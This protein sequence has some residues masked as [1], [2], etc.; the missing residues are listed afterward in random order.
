MSVRL[1]IAFAVLCVSAA[2]GDTLLHRQAP[3]RVFGRTSD[4]LFIDNAGQLNGELVADDFVL[5]ADAL[6]CK[7]RA[8]A[9][10]GGTGVDDPGPPDQE[11]VRVR[12]LS[13][14]GG[15]PNE[16]AL[17]EHYLENPLRTWTGQFINIS[18]ARKEYLYEIAMPDCFAAQAN[19][20]YWL[21]IAQIDNANSFFRWESANLAGG[22]ALRFPIDTPWRHSSETAG[23]L[24]Y[25]LW[26]PEPGSGVLVG[27]V[28]LMLRRRGKWA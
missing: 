8:Y 7:V 18:L 13:D 10:F 21:E 15:L 16:P 9:F 1:C 14:V 2:R 12:I 27:L 22:F 4:T 26:T 3:G 24:A 11:T 25:E 23:Q 5:S 20:K 6:V 19:T 28:G 17:V